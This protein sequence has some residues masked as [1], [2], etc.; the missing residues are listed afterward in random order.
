MLQP[1]LSPICQALRSQDDQKTTPQLAVAVRTYGPLSKSP[2][3]DLPS[4]PET[5][6]EQA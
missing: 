6:S 4:T 3:E 2:A 1:L 5:E